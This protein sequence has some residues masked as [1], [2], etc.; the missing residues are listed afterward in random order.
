MQVYANILKIPLMFF[1]G[2]EEIICRGAGPSASPPL[3]FPSPPLPSS[4]LPS[5]SLPSPPYPTLPSPSLEV[6]PFKSS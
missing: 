6:G 1:S 5:P 4:S 3:P 2:V